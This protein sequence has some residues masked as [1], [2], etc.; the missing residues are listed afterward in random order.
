MR[1]A[2]LAHVQSGE[3][4]FGQ[5]HQRV[6]QRAGFEGEPVAIKAGFVK[7]IA[8]GETLTDDFQRGVQ[9]RFHQRLAGFFPVM[10]AGKQD[11]RVGVEILALIQRFALRIDAVEPAA[12]F[13]I[14]EVSLQ[15][16]EQRGRTLFC[17]IHNADQAGKQI[18]LP[19]TG[20]RPITL[21]W[22]GLVRGVECFVGQ[23]HVGIPARA[24]PERH[25]HVDEVLLHLGEQ[26]GQ[27]RQGF[28]AGSMGHWR[29]SSRL[30]RLRDMVA[31][32]RALET[33]SLSVRLREQARSHN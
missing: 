8:G 24:L 33:R 21:R 25:D 9:R 1:S 17:V 26:G 12:V 29:T 18:Q 22:Q 7:A 4:G 13:G 31:E 14:V 6:L 30:G 23:C 16:T 15:R 11:E 32:R 27:F 20:H 3:E 28:G 5:V 10:R 2:V 19:C